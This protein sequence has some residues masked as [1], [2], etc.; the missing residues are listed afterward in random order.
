LGKFIGISKQLFSGLKR[1]SAF[2]VIYFSTLKRFCQ[3]LFEN[4]SKNTAKAT[5]QALAVGVI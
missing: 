1:Q 5:F 3:E 4:F 2:D